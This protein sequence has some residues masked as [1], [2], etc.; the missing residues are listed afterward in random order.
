MCKTAYSCIVTCTYCSIFHTKH[1]PICLP[2]LTMQMTSYINGGE[3]K[4]LLKKILKIRIYFTL[5]DRG[6]E[7]KTEGEKHRV[8]VSCVL[9]SNPGGR[10]D[11]EPNWP[12]FDLLGGRP[13]NWAPPVRPENTFL[14]GESQPK[15]RKNDGI[16]KWPSGNHHDDIWCRQIS[17]IGAKTPMLQ[18]L[19][20]GS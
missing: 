11:W 4:P 15:R 6:R 12:P 19:A 7:G 17:S 14:R 18:S 16:G 3:G 5:W 1:K 8:V 13:T 20:M 2:R 10:P 9:A